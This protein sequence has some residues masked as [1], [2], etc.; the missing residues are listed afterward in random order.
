[1]FVAT[2]GM[3][4]ETTIMLVVAT[5]MFR[6]TTIMSVVATGI[7]RG[8]TIMFVVAR[9]GWR[10]LSQLYLSFISALF[11]LCRGFISVVPWLYPPANSPLTHR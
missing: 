11:Q 1:M 2:A 6:E 3:F 7:F 5:G 8:T 4:R 10:R 9:G